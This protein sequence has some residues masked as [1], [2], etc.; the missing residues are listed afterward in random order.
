ML[1]SATSSY[2]KLGTLN[3]FDLVEKK[4]GVGVEVDDGV[5]KATN[6]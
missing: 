6:W 1:S 4:D 3:V 5:W 2:E